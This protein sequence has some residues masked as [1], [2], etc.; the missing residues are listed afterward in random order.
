MVDFPMPED[1]G[2]PTKD[3]RGKYLELI[4]SFSLAFWFT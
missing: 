4:Q 3:D 1:T 2:L